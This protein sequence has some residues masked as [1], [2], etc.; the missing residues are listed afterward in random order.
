MRLSL[1]TAA[2][3]AALLFTF[4][5]SP[6]NQ[7][8]ENE[9]KPAVEKPVT[10]VQNAPDFTLNGYGLSV[11]VHADGGRITSFKFNNSEFL[12]GKDVHPSNFG[13]TFWTS[14]QSSW[15]WPPREAI[16]SKAYSIQADS[17]SVKLTSTVDSLLKVTVIKTLKL[18]PD[19]TFSITYTIKN[20]GEKSQKIAP[21]EITRVPK[22][23]IAFYPKG[24]VRFDFS[25]QTLVHGI[26]N[27]RAK[28]SADITSFS[29]DE[30][31][32]KNLTGKLFADG[33]DGWLAYQVGANLL[34]KKFD[35]VKKSEIAP[36]EGEIELF[37][38]KQFGYVEIE[39]QG[40]YKDVNP[41]ESYSWTVTWIPKKYS[42]TDRVNYV[43]NSLKK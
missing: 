2:L 37:T 6:K 29:F 31:N 22:G 39:Q 35:D 10:E 5:E 16:D 4:C 27:I 33:K 7:E 25:K 14:P 12:T 24:E 26:S 40:A 30:K 17:E 11:N 9:K 8:S 43:K 15:G 36:N 28:D 19:S 18:N 20:D 3:P 13:S 34:I 42:G 41:G 23:G 38:D 32:A 21:W 1:I